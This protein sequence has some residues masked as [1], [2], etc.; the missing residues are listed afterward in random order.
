M[1]AA[2]RIGLLLFLFSQLALCGFAQHG[3]IT[4]YVG[5]GLPVNGAQA[6]TQAID[7]TSGVAADGSGGFYVSS[8]SQN[9][10]YRVVADGSLSLAAGVG[11][12]GFSGDGGP[13]T[14]AQ[15]SSP[16]GM[17]IDSAGNLYI[18]DSGSNRIRKVTPAGIIS[19]VAGNGKK[20]HSGDGGQA[21]VAKLFE[22]N[23]VA[24]DSAGNLFI[25]DL[26][27]YRIRKVTQ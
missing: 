11:S 7:D 22:P 13:A 1:K 24:V 10:I 16:L 8:R 26:C 15:I 12:S 14:A 19:T 6:N 27:N 17:A 5:P 20:G 18:A 9:R 4:T 2:Q 21:T 3:I 25:T 23:Y